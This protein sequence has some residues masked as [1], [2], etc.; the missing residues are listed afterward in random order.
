MVRAT[1]HR[2]VVALSIAAFSFVLHGPASHAADGAKALPAYHLEVG[3]ELTYKDNSEM[4]NGDGP[5][6]SG[7]SF[8]TDWKASVVGK[9][10]DGSHRVVVRSAQT[11]SFD[12]KSSGPA[13]TSLGYCDVFDDGRVIANPT[14]GFSMDPT[15]LFPRLPANAKEVASGWENLRDHDDGR[16]AFKVESQPQ[17]ANGE[18]TIGEVQKSPM[19]EIYLITRKS[20]ITFDPN[21]GLVTKAKGDTTQ[22]WGIKGKGNDTLTLVSVDKHDADWGKKLWADADRYFTANRAYDDKCALASKDE[23]ASKKLL[24]E[25]KAILSAA[26]KEV[27]LPLLKEQLADSLKSHDQMSKYMAEEATR[28]AKVVGHPAADFEATDLNG[29]THSLKDY[30]GKV[31]VLDF[32]YRGCGWCMRAMPQVKQLAAEFKG[33]PVVVIGMNTDRDPADAKFVVDKMGLDYTTLK[34]EHE[35]PEQYGVRGFPTMVIIDQQGKVHD[36]HVG[37]SPTLQREIGEVVRQLLAKR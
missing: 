14:L 8:H 1:V 6:Q 13:R 7:Y 26:E 2:H 23:K 21:R 36:L 37:Y 16:C 15:V 12:G 11:F 19:D 30:K 29:K 35:L 25:A 27:S 9:N 17:A 10:P 4:K 28:R 3:Q 18:W 31:V 22:G 32:W 20:T 33:A 5:K 24:D 34:I